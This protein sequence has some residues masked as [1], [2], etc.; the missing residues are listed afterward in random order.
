MPQGV[1]EKEEVAVAV[2][3]RDSLGWTGGGV[4]CG[5][6]RPRSKNSGYEKRL[7]GR[8]AKEEFLCVYA[9]KMT[10]GSI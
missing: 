5:G 8:R 4:G 2:V 6:R 1:G 3:A 7:G 9:H 10:G